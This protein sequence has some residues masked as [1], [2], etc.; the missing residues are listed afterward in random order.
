MNDDERLV[1]LGLLSIAQAYN[2]SLSLW[3]AQIDFGKSDSYKGAGLIPYATAEASWVSKYGLSFVTGDKTKL[4]PDSIERV[5]S[6]A[7]DKTDEL[8]PILAP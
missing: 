1:A 6:W 7:Y 8:R 2:D 3:K 4:T 5:W